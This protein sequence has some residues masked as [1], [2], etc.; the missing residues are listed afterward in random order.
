MKNKKKFLWCLVLIFAVLNIPLT[1]RAEAF[2]YLA[3]LNENFDTGEEIVVSVKVDTGGMPINVVKTTLHFPQDKL[4]V[5]DISKDNSIF[6][7]WPEEPKFSNESGEISF[8]GG[9]P[10]PGF[11]GKDGQIIAIKFKAKER[12]I[13][14][15]SFGE[16]AILA[17]DGKGTNIFSYAKESRYTI[18]KPAPAISSSTHS[19]QEKWYSNNNLE[20]HWE[21]PSDILEVSFALDKISDTQ[22]DK[23]SD[24]RVDSKIYNNLDDGIYYF[25]LRAKDDLDW[26]STRHFAIHIDA[27]PSDP[28]E[29]TVNNEGDPTN[30]RPI[31]YFEAIDKTSGIDYYRV[32]FE[33]G[34]SVILANP[35]IIKYQL[36]LQLPGIHSIIVRAFD[37]AGNFRENTT[38]I[39]VH[40]IEEPIITIWPKNYVAGEEK[41]Y[42]E[43]QA[44]PQVEVGIFLE[45][46]NTIFKQWRA[47][48]SDNGEWNFST[49]ELLRA[50]IYNLFTK[51]KDERG[52]VSEPSP[53]QQI[54]VIFS[55]IALGSLLFTFRNLV[56]ILII[57]LL[58]F[59]VFSVYFVQ[60]NLKA[61]KKLRKETQEA[62]QSL[63]QGFI[64]LKK[65]IET[66]IEKLKGAKTKAELDKKESEIIKIL[67]ENLKEVEK[68]IGKEIKD[69]DMGL[70]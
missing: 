40:P 26:S 68:Y 51:A 16:S 67:E 63:S 9:A 55:G 24:G 58:L 22:A 19:D 62:E 29:I 60:R 13:A 61:R 36:P 6:S 65:D 52:A 46:D 14:V 1:V 47:R 17:S 33:N 2:L 20:L 38:G 3:P 42:I 56:L 35:A 66:E 15:F 48:A 49:T 8:L 18:N 69:I 57:L 37:K 50:G 54:E 12:G 31:L 43:G 39:V 45:K 53:Q 30:P 4:A 10:Q 70:K 34:D 64:E 41:F 59:I 28:F 23:I 44:I 21:L 7:L 25:H 5:I 32:E 11:T 27:A